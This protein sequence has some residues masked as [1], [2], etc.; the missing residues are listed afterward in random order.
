MSRLV[1]A[2]AAVGA[3]AA[4]ATS[5]AQTRESCV[6]E[7]RVGDPVAE[8]TLGCVPKTKEFTIYR[9]SA[10]EDAAIETT[11]DTG[12][13]PTDYSARIEWQGSYTFFVDTILTQAAQQVLRG[14]L[15]DG[16]GCPIPG[17]FFVYAKDWT[18]T[19]HVKGEK[20]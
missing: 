3:L 19:L 18:C 20:Q 1:L 10:G 6:R 5:L 8:I 4:T 14:S 17:R 12:R 9:R 16:R 2:L 11:F 7:A 15:S 13:F